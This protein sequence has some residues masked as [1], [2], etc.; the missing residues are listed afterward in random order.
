MGYA[1]TQIDW[2]FLMQHHRIPTRLPDWTTNALAAPFFALEGYQRRAQEGRS[3]QANSAGTSGGTAD[4]AASQN[5]LAVL[6]GR[7][8]LVSRSPL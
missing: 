5:R 3:G 1:K 2:Y 4:L 7:R 8:V 6:D